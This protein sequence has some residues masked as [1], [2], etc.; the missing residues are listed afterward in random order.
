MKYNYEALTNDIIKGVTHTKKK[1]EQTN[2][3]E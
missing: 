1:E 2:E 3:Q